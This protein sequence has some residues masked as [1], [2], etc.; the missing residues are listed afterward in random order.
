MKDLKETDIE[1]YLDR[2]DIEDAK[3]DFNTNILVK[4]NNFSQI[5]RNGPT[6]KNLKS[7]VY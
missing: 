7:G 2:K 1:V 6:M 4:C 3:S 5:K